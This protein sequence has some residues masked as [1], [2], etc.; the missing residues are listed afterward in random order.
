MLKVF[1][2][3]LSSMIVLGVVGFVSVAYVFWLFGSDL[4][5]YDHL[6]TYE[7]PITTRVYAADGRLMAE[8]A[9][10]K[11][12]YVPIEA[13]PKRVS[14]AFLSAEDKSF[15]SHPG[16]DVQGLVRAV[17]TNVRNMNTGRRPV[18][19]STITQQVAKNF[20]LTNEVSIER[21]I[22]EALLAFR[23]EQAFTKD[24]ILELY[25][26]EIYLGFQSYGIAAAALNYFNK[27]VDELTIAEAAFLAALPKAPNNYHP[28]R[29]REAAYA[30][31]NWVIGRMLEDGHITPDE[32]E[33]ARAE[34]IVLRERDDTQ[35]VFGAGFFSEEIRRTLA[36]H[37]G[38][39]ALYKGGLA[40]RATLD[41]ELQRIAGRVLR[42]G[43]IAYDR[44]HGW[45]G[46]VAT[47]AVEAGWTEALADVPRP[48]GAPEDWTL[49]L[50]L[51]VERGAVTLGLPDGSQ[52]KMPFDTMRWARPWRDDQRVGPA[53]DSADDVLS[54]GDVVL[55]APVTDDE[56]A[57]TG[58]YGLQQ[59]PDIEGALVAMDPHTGRVLAMMGGFSAERSEFNRATQAL[60]QPGS[61]FKPFVY[62]A[63]LED[64]YT[65]ASI[66]LDAPFVYD[67]GPGLAKWKPKNYSNRFYGPSTLRMGVEKSRNLM[68]VRLAQAV[69][70]DAVAD[71]A[72]RFGVARD[73]P[74]Y[75][76]ASLGSIETTVLRLTTAY[77]M[78]AN[79]GRRIEAT[80]VDRI[81]DRHGRTIY[82]HDARPCTA[83]EAVPWTGQAVP[84]L[85]DPRGQ[86]I[87]PLTAYQMVSI[88]E[89]VVRRGTGGR[90]GAA[91]QKPLAGKTG[92]SN[93]SFDT[94]FVGFAPDLAVGVFVGFDEPRT[95]GPREAGSTAAGPIFRDFMLAALEDQPGRPFR[96][97]PGIE[98]VT[99]DRQTGRRAS[100]GD[101]TIT[102]AFKPGEGPVSN[103]EVLDG[104]A[105]AGY[106]GGAGTAA[107]GTPSTLGV[108]IVPMPGQWGSAGQPA[109]GPTG[110]GQPL[111]PGQPV[112]PGGGQVGA[113][114]P[115][116]PGGGGGAAPQAGGLY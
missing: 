54:A 90:I 73:M 2:L 29:E 64:G 8:Y 10:E 18:G 34:E 66:I 27:S 38:E 14:N 48:A 28:V 74:Q 72:E 17:I 83:C 71:V 43:L 96:V 106:G 37:Y 105:V 31:R 36:Q 89:G 103:P 55:V 13:I 91:I 65:P 67:Q 32:A 20:L 70:M 7:P 44:R 75:L 25:L 45:R 60:R 1:R 87:D 22:R 42:E 104:S 59:L 116:P 15:Y 94:W 3:V 39:E 79:G 68:T 40:V 56:G 95:L 85:P 61:A 99:I 6:K 97:P 110:T 86:V 107:Y 114:P 24:H 26:N 98:F 115:P 12:I 84:S 100:G 52:A 92:T 41:P 33:R 63:A 57:P 82:R 69:G 46:P 93:D 16:I 102:E 9:I 53:P 4:P 51:K 62:M 108:G 35:A 5:A 50:A 30:R 77:A 88:L 109:A 21:K 113:A 49:A 23:L 19:A 81:Q 78:I 112:P 101:G 76:A 80:L 58:T 11:R 111:R 47:L